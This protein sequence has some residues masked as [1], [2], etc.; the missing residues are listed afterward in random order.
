[1]KNKTKKQVTKRDLIKLTNLYLKSK[2]MNMGKE[3]IVKPVVEAVLI[4]I[5][6]LLMNN[7]A[8]N[9]RGFGSFIIEDIK[10]DK[11]IIGG[12]EY[13]IRNK[14]KIKFKWSKKPV[15]YSKGTSNST[16]DSKLTSQ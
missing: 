1:M 6:T 10:K 11:C 13:K 3:K 14:K 12:K 2:S 9:I 16:N 7:I 8:I 4:S 15:I 5:N